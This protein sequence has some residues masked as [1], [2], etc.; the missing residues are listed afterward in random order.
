MSKSLRAALAEL[1][2][3]VPQS[4]PFAT[5]FAH[6]SKIAD[7]LGVTERTL[8]RHLAGL[9]SEGLIEVMPQERK[10]RNGRYAVARIRLTPKAAALV[11]LIEAP[12]DVIHTPPSDNLS[13]G[14]SLSEPTIAK[15]H[16]PV[17]T[18]GALPV[19]LAHLTGQ[20][21]SKAGLFKLMGIAKAH[22]KRLSDIVAA[23]ANRLADFKGGRLYAYLAKLASGPTDFSVAAT[24][25]REAA[26]KAHEAALLHTRVARFKERFRGA[27]L[28]TRSGDR[29]Y[30]IDRDARYVQ[31][32]GMD[33]SG[34]APMN[35]L[36]PWIQAVE[37][38]DLVLATFD[39]ERRL[40]CQ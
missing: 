4:E 9:K 28:A 12:K 18:I 24:A 34:T 17:A 36:L 26:A 25:A 19:D 22:G 30:R 8:Y 35:D 13:V 21:L 31:V 10:S 5:V 20:G 23:M 38:G 2:R 11:G 39:V 32:L 7:R 40:N 37:R 27:T 16:R 6:K 3:Y 33:R 15:N 14:H 29:L 1:V